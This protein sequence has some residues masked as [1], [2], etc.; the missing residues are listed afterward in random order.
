MLKDNQILIVTMVHKHTRAR[1]RS[2]Y[3]G[4]LK[5]WNVSF[6]RHTPSALGLRVI[7]D[8]YTFGR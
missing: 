3:Q 5:G 8:P 7:S 4:A 6:M 2:I 1:Q